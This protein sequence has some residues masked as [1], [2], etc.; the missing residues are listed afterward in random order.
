MVILFSLPVKADELVVAVASN[1][2][3]TAKILAENF[4]KETK[5]KV[6]FV[7]GSTGKLFTQIEQGAPYDVFM[8]ADS[9]RPEKLIDLKLAISEGKYIYAKGLLVFLGEKN[10][11]P[12]LKEWLEQQANKKIALAN[13]KTA[14]YGQAALEVIRKLQLEDK[15]RPAFVYG[16]N[17]AQSYQYVESGNASSGF[18]AFSTVIQEKQIS[19][20]WILVDSSHY[21]PID[22]VAVVLT[23]SKRK[24]SG[25]AWI[26]FLKDQRSVKL[27]RERGYEV[28]EKVLM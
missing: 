17:V 19:D 1:F 5:L 6:E 3:P 10:H 21:K 18:V 26:T 2:L 8:A 20:K 28:T 25:L 24:K 22:Q 9:E 15:L 27:I 16:S 11:P 7:T 13:P 23:A 4:E 14:P 12:G